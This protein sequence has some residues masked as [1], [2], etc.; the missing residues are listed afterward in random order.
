MIP[1]VPALGR[2]LQVDPIE[3]GGANDCSW[4]NDPIN[5]H[6]LSGE[7][8]SI[9]PV[10]GESGPKV[11]ASGA[12]YVGRPV[13]KAAKPVRWGFTILS[14]VGDFMNTASFIAGI[15]STGLAV[16]AVAVKAPQIAAPL[17]G[18]ASLAG[19]ASAA[20]G[21]VGITA[22]CVAHVWD[23]LCQLSLGGATVGNVMGVLGGPV[24]GLLAG[25]IFGTLTG[26]VMF[27]TSMPGAARRPELDW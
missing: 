10:L 9:A 12:R 25:G 16:G 19:Y 1:N 18:L 14:T 24:G 6:D 27:L 17:L 4:P 23:A 26:G 11:K 5:G 21:T 15:V 20:F 2:I 22:D 8:W 13:A 3:G 7:R